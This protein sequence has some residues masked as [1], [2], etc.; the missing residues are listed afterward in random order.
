MEQWRVSQDD[1]TSLVQEMVRIVLDP[2]ASNREKT[3]AFNAVA[4]V[5]KQ[6]EKSK[7]DVHESRNRFLEIAQRLGIAESTGRIIDVAATGS[8][9]TAIT[10]QSNG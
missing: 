1:R 2:S 8:D 4:S 6:E 3:S 5:T 9:S 10:E 7:N